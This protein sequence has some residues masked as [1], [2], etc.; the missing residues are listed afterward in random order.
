MTDS[1]LIRASD[2]LRELAR[3]FGPTEP[4]LTYRQVHNLILDAKIPA[5]RRHNGDRT[6]WIARTDLAAIAE[7]LGMRPRVS[8]KVPA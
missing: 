7:V 6:L 1:G 8:S 3:D 5:H 4:Q 2:L